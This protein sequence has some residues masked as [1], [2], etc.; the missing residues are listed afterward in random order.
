MRIATHSLLA[1]ATLTTGCLSLHAD[2]PEDVIRRH[3]ALEDGIELGAICSLEGKGY[4]E[5]AVAC[6]AGQL[7]TCDPA[8]RWSEGDRC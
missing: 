3:S 8:G 5:G 4:S 6:M 2:I 7:M 1:L